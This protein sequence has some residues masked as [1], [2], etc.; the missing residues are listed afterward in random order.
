MIGP[1]AC[2]R[3]CSSAPRKTCRG[4]CTTKNVAVGRERFIYLLR[5]FFVANFATGMFFFAVLV[6]VVSVFGFVVDLV[7][8]AGVF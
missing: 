4:T 8:L 7:S 5:F 1:D 2:G 3:L 6:L